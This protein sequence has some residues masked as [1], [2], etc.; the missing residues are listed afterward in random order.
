[1]YEDPIIVTK[2]RASVGLMLTTGNVTAAV[3]AATVALAHSGDARRELALLV[4]EY[5]ALVADTVTAS[6]AAT[7]SLPLLTSGGAILG[8]V[9]FGWDEPQPFDPDQV[10]WLDRI[11]DMVAQAVARAARYQHE[12]DEDWARQEAGARVL[13]EAFLPSELPRTKHLQVAAAYLPASD[14]GMGG[15]WYDVF[16]VDGG[17]CIVIGDVAGHGLRCVAVMAQLRNAARAF[18]DEDPTPATIVSRLNRM[19]CRLEPEETATV[20][21]A[22][23]DPETRTLMRANAGHPPLLRCRIGEFSYVLP[24]VGDIMLGVDASWRYSQVAKV[25]R[26]GTTLVLYTDGLIE[27]RREILDRGMDDLLAFVERSQDLSPGALCNDI[28]AW[29]LGRG[30]RDDDLCILAVRLV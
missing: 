4:Q 23:W 21:V 17:T 19:L 7:A 20:I 12:R 9:G 10:R 2:L 28:L 30:R 26:P 6:L 24:T 18:A 29:R 22:V 14:A 16:P 11:A 1:M 3:R 15:D 25:L 8:A 5:P 13:Q 27:T